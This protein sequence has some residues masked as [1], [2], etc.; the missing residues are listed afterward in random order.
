MVPL[1]PFKPSDFAHLFSP[2]LPPPILPPIGA[3]TAAA[4]SGDDNT[5][6]YWGMGF[7]AAVFVICTGYSIYQN[8]QII[9]G[10]EAMKEPKERIIP[11]I[12]SYSIAN[13]QNENG[14]NQQPND[15]DVAL[16]ALEY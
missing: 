10:L 9:K 3:A 1:Q 8:V 2:K 16:E 13:K 5:L 7:L 12:A 15:Q 6:F 14:N 11:A 4:P